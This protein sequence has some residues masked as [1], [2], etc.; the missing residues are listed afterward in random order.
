MVVVSP[1]IRMAMFLSMYLGLSWRMSSVSALIAYL[2]PKNWLHGFS[3]FRIVK[4]SRY[5]RSMTPNFC[6]SR[7][8]SAVGEGGRMTGT[9]SFVDSSGKGEEAVSGVLVS[10]V[11][12]SLS[13]W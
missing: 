13:A 3:S 9:E 11:D 12:A 10:V 4:A 2:P 8:L 7:D 6:G 1:L 5:A